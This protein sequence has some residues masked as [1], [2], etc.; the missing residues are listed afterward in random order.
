MAIVSC[1]AVGGNPDRLIGTARCGPA[2]RVV[3]DPWLV[4]LGS[5]SH[6]D[7]IGRLLKFIQNR[8]PCTDGFFKVG[9]FIT[10]H[11]VTL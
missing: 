11:G 5:V 1:R 8:F 9:A 4:E 6:G 3:W 10:F 7:P 2:C